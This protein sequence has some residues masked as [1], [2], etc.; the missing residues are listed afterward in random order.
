MKCLCSFL[1][2]L[3]ILFLKIPPTLF[4][5]AGW[6]YFLANLPF[7]QFEDLHDPVL[8]LMD[9]ALVARHEARFP[10]RSIPLA[11]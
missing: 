2:L 3:N 7:P 10:Y 9:W 8:S 5:I 11:I 6:L 4:L 1:E